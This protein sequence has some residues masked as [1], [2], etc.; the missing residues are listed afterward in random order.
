[1]LVDASLSLASGEFLTLLGPSGC[2]K[3]TLLRIVAGLVEPNLG[4]VEF[5]GRDVTTMPVHRREIGMVFQ[6][7][8]AVS[9][10]DRGRER[11]LRPEDA[12]SCRRQIAEMQGDRQP[13]TLVRLRAVPRAAMPQR[14]VRRPAAAG[15][16]GARHR[17]QGRAVL[18]ARRAVR[19]ARPRSCGEALQ[20]ELRDGTSG[21]SASPPSSSPTI[22]KKR[23]YSAT[24]SRS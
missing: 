3:T 2:G 7:L 23:W 8:C 24:G 20:V 5:G 14:A 15:G 1:M 13:S 12:R 22:R 16:A 18:L 6:A 11:R 9:A 4:T 17:D 21:R 19:R 10:H